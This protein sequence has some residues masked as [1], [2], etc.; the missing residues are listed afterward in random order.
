VLTPPQLLHQSLKRS[1]SPL[2]SYAYPH[3]TYKD[4]PIDQ[5]TIKFSGTQQTSRP[6]PSTGNAQRLTFELPTTVHT[7]R[8]KLDAIHEVQTGVCWHARL[9]SG[10]PQSSA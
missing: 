5:L 1:V 4:T 7:Q 8:Y 10:Y 9:D 6:M 2:L 3:P